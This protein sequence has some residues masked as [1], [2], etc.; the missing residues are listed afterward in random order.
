MTQTPRISRASEQAVP[1][2]RFW[3]GYKK[4]ELSRDEMV[5]L[6]RTRL[7]PHTPMVGAGHGLEAYLPAIPRQ[8]RTA[9]PVDEFALVVYGSEAEYA[10]LRNLKSGRAYQDEHGD[11]FQMR[12]AD[13]TAVSHSRVAGVYQGN[14]PLLPN[15]AYLLRGMPGENWQRGFNQTRILMRPSQV[16][17]TEFMDRAREL[18]V[19]AKNV[20]SSA[21][22][23]VA[24]LVDADYLLVYENWKSKADV[25][26]NREEQLGRSFDV[27]QSFAPRDEWITEERSSIREGVALNVRFDPRKDLPNG[28]LPADLPLSADD[29]EKAISSAGISVDLTDFRR[30]LDAARAG[31]GTIDRNEVLF[32]GRLLST[33]FQSLEPETKAAL[34]ALYSEHHVSEDDLWPGRAGTYKARLGL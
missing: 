9:F 4:P 1:F 29:I 23:D 7:V 21:L 6:L 26:A 16:S 25:P 33:R 11:I 30:I 20:S 17:Q 24:V 10:A 13:G 15:A 5:E 14:G 18:L 28:S 22:N 12:S 34:K 31:D 3:R 19:E 32:I 8:K 27:S 2:V